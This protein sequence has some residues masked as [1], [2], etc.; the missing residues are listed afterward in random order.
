MVIERAKRYNKGKVRLDLIPEQLLIELGKVYTRGAHKYSLYEDENGNIIK[1][2]DIPFTEVSNYK[3]I[4]DGANNWRKGQVFS[5]VYASAL[6]HMVDWKLGKDID[7]DP[8]MLTHNLASAIWNLTTLLIFSKTHPELDDRTF[9]RVPKVGLDI[10][11]VIADYTGHYIQYHNFS[12]KERPKHYNDP[13][14]RN[15]DFYQK[16]NLDKDFFLNIPRMIN[17]DELLFEPVCYVTARHIPIEWTQ[18]WL[19]INGFP[20]ATLISVGDSPKSEVLKDFEL[21]YFIDDHYENFVELN[22]AGIPT[23]LFTQPHNVKYEVGSKRINN[24]NDVI[25]VNNYQV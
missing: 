25:N 19:N 11:N 17:P 4:E 18:E 6:R 3:V 15:P 23:L 13:R 12:N 16:S 9:V 1:G 22:K 7:S 21:D 20:M 2:Q 5:E 24:I 14:F 10:D 8:S